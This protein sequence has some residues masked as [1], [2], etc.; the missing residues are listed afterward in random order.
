MSPTVEEWPVDDAPVLRWAVGTITVDSDGGRS[1]QLD[2]W[3]LGADGSV[4]GEPSIRIPDAGTFA[5]LFDHTGEY[6]ATRR[7]TADSRLE[8][9]LAHTGG[10]IELPGDPVFGP[11]WHPTEPRLA[12]VARDGLSGQQQLTVASV[13][14]PELDVT[15]VAEVPRATLLHS[16]GDWGF[17]ASAGMVVD[18][19]D[20][21]L[22]VRQV[23]Y[24]L[25]PDGVVLTGSEVDVVAAAR[26]GS[27]MLV[28]NFALSENA[29]P[30]LGFRF[31]VGVE[32]L[33]IDGAALVDRSFDVLDLPGM[34]DLDEH[35]PSSSKAFHLSDDGTAAI[36]VGYSNATGEAQ[37]YLIELET[38]STYTWTLAADRGSLR[39]LHFVDG[40][41]TVAYTTRDG[42]M[43]LLDT[44]LGD[45]YVLGPVVAPVADEVDLNA[46]GEYE[47][48]VAVHVGE[49]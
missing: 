25:D 16:W 41:T 37:V 28:D 11:I 19:D 6:V 15:S 1:E 32:P 27:L 3:T 43:R 45:E 47:L 13:E 46:P 49:S 5:V 36:V 17:V 7:L 42:V 26:G 39:S 33:G 14:G 44:Y 24:A 48:V 31:E 8:L 9:L 20:E 2:V 22:R 23:A 29:V 12:Y 40:G 21:S 34:A 30:E 35:Y 38:G 4:L 10:V 18:S